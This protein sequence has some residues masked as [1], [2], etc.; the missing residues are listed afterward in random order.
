MI[1]NNRNLISTKVRVSFIL[2]NYFEYSI[3][4]CFVIY[5]KSLNDSCFHIMKTL[6]VF[7]E[8]VK[9]FLSEPVESKHIF[10]LI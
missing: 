9:M 5:G 8:L 6:C 7:N 2:L 4:I 1:W 10:D 3:Y